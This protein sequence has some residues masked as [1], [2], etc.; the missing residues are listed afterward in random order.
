VSRDALERIGGSRLQHGELSSRVYLM[1]L[2]P[3]DAPRVLERMRGLAGLNGYTKLF[4]KIPAKAAGPFL[5][6]GFITEAE[7]PDFYPDGDAVLFL[8]RFL[9]EKRREPSDP[10]LLNRVLE[11]AREKTAGDSSASPANGYELVELGEKDAESMAALYS[12]VFATYPFPIFDPGYLIRTMDENF[13]YFGAVQGN[14]LVA[15][16]SSEMDDGCV[17]MTD[18]AT[19][20]EHRGAGLAGRILRRME[21][22][23]SAARMKT[24]FTIARARSFGVNILF[25]RAGYSFA[26]TLVNNTGISGRLE[27]MNVWYKPL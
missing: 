12:K 3:E 21:R 13:R 2:E 24:A 5:A 22:E 17:E 6:D 19:D 27:S 7:I 23:M 25:S 4:A 9:S 11:T 18:F 16:A 10:G 15:Q 8:A 26:G 14:E 20:P 1:H